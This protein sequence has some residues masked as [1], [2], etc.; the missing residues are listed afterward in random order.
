MKKMKL[1][2]YIFTILTAIAFASCSNDD[3][4][5]TSIYTDSTTPKN[6]FDEWLLKNYTDT[7]NICINYR[8]V[9]NETDMKYNLVPAQYDKSIALA[10]MI[11]YIWIDSYNELLGNEDF[12]KANAP[13][14]FQFVGSPG[15]DDGSYVMGTADAGMKITLYNVNQ[16]NLD[17]LD[18]ESLNYWYFHVIFHEF[19]HIL[20]QTKSYSTDFNLITPTNYQS[21]SWVNVSDEDALHMGFITAYGS[22]EPNEDFVEIISNYVT[23]TEDWWENQLAVAKQTIVSKSTYDSYDGSDN[24]E[25]KEITTTDEDGNK[26]TTYYI[27][28]GGDELLLRKFEIIKNYLDKSWGISIEKLRDIVQRRSNNLQNMNFR[29]L[30]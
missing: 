19:S 13:K 5:S 15:Y 27:Y 21:G 8:L 18:L 11:K 26:V 7:F 30:D 23:N 10:K 22:S 25:K 4:S 29:D 6:S 1:F 3:L 20:H 14:L 24:G 17:N 16:I 9:D 12:I 28:Y 2:K